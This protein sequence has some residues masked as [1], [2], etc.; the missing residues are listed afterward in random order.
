MNVGLA[1]ESKGDLS[2]QDSDA[3]NALDLALS[4]LREELGLDNDRLLG[5]QA[6][7]QDLEVAL[8]ITTKQMN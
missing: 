2:S 6:L 8:E 7:A 4:A 1:F 3:T 5:Q